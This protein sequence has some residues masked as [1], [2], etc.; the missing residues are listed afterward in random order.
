MIHSKKIAIVGMSHRLPGG[1]GSVFWDRLVAG[2]DLVTEVEDGRW[3]KDKFYHPRKSEPAS[4]YTKA[5]GSLRDVLEFD[6][7]SFR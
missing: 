3:A 1:D 5:S 2:E 7:V 4:T 6:A